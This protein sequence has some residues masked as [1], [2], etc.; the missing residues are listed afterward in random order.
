MTLSSK[1]VTQ[2]GDVVRIAKEG[3]PLHNQS[4]RK[5]DLVVRYEVEF[6]KTLTTEQKAGFERI[7][8]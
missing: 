6:P 5:G 8:K 1:G 2:H 4:S 7:L 3:M